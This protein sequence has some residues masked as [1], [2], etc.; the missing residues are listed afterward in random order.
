MAEPKHLAFLPF[1]V[2]ELRK[3]H[4]EKKSGT[5][6]ATTMNQRLAQFGLDHGEIVYLSFQ[7]VEGMDGLAML[8]S[9]RT[10]VGAS[11]FAAGR[12]R[13]EHLKLPPFE[14]LLRTLQSAAGTLA[15]SGTTALDDHVRA[16]VEHELTDL[17]GPYAGVM[18]PEI[19]ETATTL[20]QAL[21]AIARELDN[22]QK[23][24]KLYV[25]VRKALG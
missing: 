4:D 14:D 18:L 23:S 20:E 21:I 17:I 3:L 13:G 1:L 7:N 9:Q 22:A 25:N 12:H 16:I 19:W 6:F 15:R 2:G 24:E 11:R 5:L 8:A 10:E